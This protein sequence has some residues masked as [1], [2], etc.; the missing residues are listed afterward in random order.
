[1]ICEEVSRQVSR[2]LNEVK[3]SLNSQI[4][5]AI[6][7]AITEKVLPSIQKTLDTQ[8]KAN[9][10][11]VDRGTRGLQKGPRRTYF[12]LMDQRSNWLQESP[13]TNSFTV[14][15]QRSSGLQRSLEVEI[16]QKTWENQSKTCFAHENCRQMSRESSVDSYTGEQN[17][18]SY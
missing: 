5:D 8:G 17:H 11:V 12:T 13:R 10:T 6:T 15:G 2:K 4:Q 16:S 14:V 3:D 18:D 9:F 7:T 1:M